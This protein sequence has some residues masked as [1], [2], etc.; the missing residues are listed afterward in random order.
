[1]GVLKDFIKHPKA[2]APHFPCLALR[3]VF[4]VSRCTRCF[5][6]SP[7]FFPFSRVTFKVIN[8]KQKA[9]ILNQYEEFNSMIQAKSCTIVAAKRGE[10]KQ[11]R[12]AAGKSLLHDF[13]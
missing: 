2:F 12:K 5:L 11:P 8:A 3:A 9:I 4:C 13:H 10:K 1:M 7:M 6:S